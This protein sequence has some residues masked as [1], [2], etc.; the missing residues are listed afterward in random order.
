MRIVFTGYIRTFSTNFNP[1]IV[2]LHI[3]M[4]QSISNETYVN[5]FPAGLTKVSAD[6]SAS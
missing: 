1:P 4:Q 6:H 2:S 5:I 3:N